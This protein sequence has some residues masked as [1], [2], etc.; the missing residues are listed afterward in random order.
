MTSLFCSLTIESWVKCVMSWIETVIFFKVKIDL[1]RVQ[2]CPDKL[3]QISRLDD[4][5]VKMR[6]VSYIN[7]CLGESVNFCLSQLMF[8]ISIVVSLKSVLIGGS[9]I[10]RMA[11]GLSIPKLTSFREEIRKK[12]LRSLQVSLTPSFIPPPLIKVWSCH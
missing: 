9:S 6:S 3:V 5:W 1:Y 2:F 10:I 11:R 12:E 7:K 4:I 8:G